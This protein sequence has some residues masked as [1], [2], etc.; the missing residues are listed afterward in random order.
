VTRDERVMLLAYRCLYPEAVEVGGATVLR[1]AEAPDS[2]MLNRVAGIGCNEPAT[3]AGLDE[4]LDAIGDDVTCYVS[5]S[6]GAQPVELE[7]WLCARGLEPGW[8]WM[9]FR[10][11]V[12]DVPDVKTSLRLAEIDAKTA[13]AFGRIVATGYGLPE[14]IVPICARAHEVGWDCWIALDG[15]EPVAA[16]GVYVA[17]GAGYLGFAA[18]LPEHRG[19]G[20]Q[21]ALFA[22]RIVRARERGCDT[23]LTET[24]ELRD[25]LPGNS[26][27][28]ILR[29][30]FEEVAVTANW[31]RRAR[32]GA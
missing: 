25:G 8:G 11:G 7:D 4:A 17:E 5:V 1:S 12:T 29:A 18:T 30:G 27:R 15:D 14:A 13:D 6:P 31:L 16:A 26:Y 2:P 22:A 10:R 24:G 32:P 21:S 3:E 19:K 20:A 28:N 9:A 23:V